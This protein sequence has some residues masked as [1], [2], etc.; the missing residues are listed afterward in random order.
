MSPEAKDRWVDLAHF[1]YLI[2]V[3][4]LESGWT[5]AVMALGA[6]V[7]W[8][9]VTR[10]TWAGLRGFF[11]TAALLVQAVVLVGVALW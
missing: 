2:G 3:P 4:H 6:L 8:V 11:L 9:V 10:P 1:A 7:L 5:R